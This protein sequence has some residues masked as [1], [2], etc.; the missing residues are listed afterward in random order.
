MGE[1]IEFP[2]KRDTFYIPANMTE[3]EKE[4][5]VKEIMRVIFGDEEDE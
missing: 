4:A 1:I 5:K 3:E 2:L